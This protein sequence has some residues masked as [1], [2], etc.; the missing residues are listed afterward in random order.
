MTNS[1]V[2][3]KP[4]VQQASVLF[5]AGRLE[6]AKQALS[7]LV[8]NP[9]LDI[10]ALMLLGMVMRG[11]QQIA[12]AVTYFSSAHDLAP[13]NPQILNVYANSLA[14]VGEVQTAIDKFSET[15]L[16]RPDVLESHIN[17]ALVAAQ[18]GQHKLALDTVEFGLE[19]FPDNARLLAI[20]AMALRNADRIS[21]ALPVF[22]LAL[23]ADPNRALTHRNYAATL[24]AAGD[25][26]T[27]ALE[28]SEAARLGLNDQETYLGWAA[29][30]LERGEV[31]AALAMYN[32]VNAALPF[33]DEAARAIA[34]ISVEY[35]TDSDAFEHYRATAETYPTNMHAWLRWVAATLSHNCFAET[36][37]VASKALFHFPDATPLIAA[38]LYAN[39]MMGDPATVIAELLSTVQCK[40]GDQ[41]RDLLCQ[42]A[43]KAGDGRLAAQQAEIMTTST[44]LDQSGWAYLATAWRMLGDE[45][46]HWLCDYERLI[47]EQFVNPVNTFSATD[48]FT[49]KVAETLNMLHKTLAAPGDQS[50]RG[51]TQTS[52]SLFDRQD[53]TIQALK[54]G[55]TE[56][57][58]SYIDT[59]PKDGQH[60]FLQRISNRF[61]FSGSWSVKLKAQ[62]HHVPHFH[63]QGW[64]SSAYYARLPDSLGS[65]ER[66]TDGWIGFGQPPSIY[67]TN[68]TPRKL[69]KPQEGLLVL[70]PSYMWHG[71]MPFIGDQYRLTAAFDVIPD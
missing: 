8:A 43:I 6:D 13:D 25:P 55:V 57:V 48:G 51:G 24:M 65:D 59:L 50:L 56:A 30:L 64:I 61:R 22:R 38:R 14:A 2:H 34:R 60:P 23:T 21:E 31:D 3:W 67:G 42:I 47:G 19:N 69:I 41:Y 12:Q 7:P 49:A 37:D 29:A 71:T 5:Q 63:G 52:G 39:G 62:G 10:D 33:D 45:R 18:D 66:N 15:I 16:A 4:L 1:Q 44:P 32:E 27:A 68:H 28:F 9:P 36:H 26:D 40:D 20:Q 54:R 35:R 17:L 11:T 53:A 46:E 58:Q 70:F